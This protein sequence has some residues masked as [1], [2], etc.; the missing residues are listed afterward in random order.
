TLLLD[1]VGLGLPIPVLPDVLRRFGSDPAFVSQNFGYFISL[2][3]LMQFLA[4]P[5][6]GSLSDRFGRRP[7]LLVS[8]L[9]AGLDYLFMAFAPT[10]GFLYLGRVISGLT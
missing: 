4:S 10:L 6:L 7:I 5:V 9:A 2:Y 8:L 3:A 1:A